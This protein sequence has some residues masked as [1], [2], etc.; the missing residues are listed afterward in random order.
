MIMNFHTCIMQFFVLNM[1][2][3]SYYLHVY[4]SMTFYDDFDRILNILR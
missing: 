3:S 4:Y 2:I 1:K